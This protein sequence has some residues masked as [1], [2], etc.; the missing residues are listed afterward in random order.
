MV[1]AH[2]VTVQGTERKQVLIHT[3]VSMSLENTWLKRPA[4]E[5][6]MPYHSKYTNCVEQANLQRQKDQW[7]SRAGGMGGK[8]EWGETSKGYGISLRG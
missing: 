8:G 5:D 6:H 3:T 4:T 2:K 7:L 1:L